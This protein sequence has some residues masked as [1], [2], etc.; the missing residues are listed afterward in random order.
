M[1]AHAP[2]RQSTP[3]DPPPRYLLLTATAQTAVLLVQAVAAGL[4]LA[5]VPAGRTAHSAMAGGVLLVVALHVAAAVT[6]WRRGAV[7]GRTV[8]HTTPMLLLTVVQAALGF[9]HV[10]ELHVPLGVLMFG[11]SVLTLTRIRDEK[12][13]AVA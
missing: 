10:R 11:A 9:A 3:A 8:L 6:A 2:L 12:V 4:L 1:D 5:S 7:R 13:S